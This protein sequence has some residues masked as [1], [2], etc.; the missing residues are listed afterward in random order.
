M[1]WPTEYL[2]SNGWRP[3]PTTHVEEGAWE[4]PWFSRV[5]RAW[6]ASQGVYGDGEIR[7]RQS[8]ALY[9]QLVVDRGDED[10]LIERVSRFSAAVSATALAAAK[11]ISRSDVR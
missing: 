5:P 11:Y 1:T 2:I 6:C 7:I 9:L 8:A 3:S 4:H 10:C